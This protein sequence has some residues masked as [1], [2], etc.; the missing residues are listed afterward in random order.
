[1]TATILVVDDSASVRGFIAEL[2]GTVGYTV[3]STESAETAL[4]ALTA[5]P[6]PPALIV[7]DLRLGAGIGGAELLRIATTSCPGLKG[8]LMSG[9]PPAVSAHGRISFLA[10]PFNPETLLSLVAFVLATENVLL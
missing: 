2:L 9:A 8:I 10:K 7:S 3:V 1:M 5:L 6:E 4:R